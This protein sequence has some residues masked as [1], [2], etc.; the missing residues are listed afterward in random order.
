MPKIDDIGVVKAKTFTNHLAFKFI[1]QNKQKTNEFTY[2]KSLKYLRKVGEDSEYIEL[3]ITIAIVSIV[4]SLSVVVVAT[5]PRAWE[6]ALRVPLPLVCSPPFSGSVSVC[7]SVESLRQS[8]HCPSLPLCVC[9]MLSFVCLYSLSISVSLSLTLSPSLPPITIPSSFQF[10]LVSFFLPATVHL[11]SLLSHSHTQS[12][13]PFSTRAPCY[14]VLYYCQI[15]FGAVDHDW[16]RR[17]GAKGIV[18]KV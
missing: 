17:Y 10:R 3:M 7:P 6:C 15:S 1:F 18:A 8:L 9:T 16:I 13:S 14:C 2:R 4:S 12:D 5:T 11:I